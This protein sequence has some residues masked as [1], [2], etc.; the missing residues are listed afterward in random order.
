MTDTWVERPVERTEADPWEQGE[1]WR[2]RAHELPARD[3][4]RNALH[5]PARL[6]FHSSALGKVLGYSCR[7]CGWDAPVLV[8]EGPGEPSAPLRE[9]PLSNHQ[10]A[11]LRKTPEALRA[12]QRQRAENIAK[13][14]VKR[15]KWYEGGD[16]DDDV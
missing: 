7:A 8:Q 10:L 16:C 2:L 3:C 4:A 6:Y 13:N 12:G 9:A 15:R 5:G 14:G 11:S 1:W